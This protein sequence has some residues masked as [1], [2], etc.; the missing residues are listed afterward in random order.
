MS[1]PA[2]VTAGD[3]GAAKP[4]YGESKVYLEV[5]GRSMVARV[6][7]VLQQVPEISEVWVIGDPERLAPILDAERASGAVHK[8]LH[9][10][11]Q[12]AN[13]YE[14]CWESYRR[15]LPDAGPDGRDPAS[16]DDLDQFALYLSA[17]LPFATPQE[18]SAFIRESLS[19]DCDYAL[20]LVPDRALAEF[21]NDSPDGPGIRVAY[22]NLREERYR[23]NNLHFARPARLANRR[24]VEEMYEHRHQQELGKIL[25]LAWNLARTENG[26]L[27]VL[28]YYALMHLGGVADRHGWR[29]LAD[30]LRSRI[31]IARVE[32]GVG[33]LLGTR[34]RFAVT[35]AGGCAIDVD[36]EAEYEAVQARF[37]EWQAQQRARAEALYGPPAL[38]AQ[39]GREEET[40]G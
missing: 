22:F 18:I 8:P 21:A 12:F 19:L 36:T 4:I 33:K 20:G 15:V 11:P 9:L 5:D 24:Y 7:D 3:R 10:I 39:A 23:Q 28:Y 34:F 27:V 30:L 37:S 26:G 35:E 31:R 16:E 2:I 29:W 13:L 14:N 40:G 6:I 25:G 32:R 17:D 38:P 1:F